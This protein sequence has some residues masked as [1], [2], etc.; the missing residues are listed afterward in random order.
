MFGLQ[1]MKR[2]YTMKLKDLLEIY[3]DNE[4]HR[5]SFALGTRNN[6]LSVIRMLNTMEIVEKKVKDVHTEELQK[7]FTS[8]VNGFT[9]EDGKYHKPYSKSRICAFSALLTNAFAYAVYPLG[10][11]KSNPMEHVDISVRRS[12][13]VLFENMNRQEEILTHEQFLKICDYLNEKDNPDVLP[14]EIAYYTG[15]RIGEVCGLLWDD[16]HLDEQYLVVQRAVVLNCE[17]KNRLEF[18]SPKRDKGRIVYFPNSLK[19]IL[20]QEKKK[21]KGKTVR[22]YYMQV[23]ENETVHY[24]LYFGYSNSK[25]EIPVDL[26]C[27]KKDGSYINRR[28]LSCMCTRLNNYIDGLQNFHFHMLR[29]TYATNLI[30][31]GMNME[32]IRQL[33]GHNDIRTTMNIYVHNRDETLLRKVRKLDKMVE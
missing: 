2:R 23:I 28:S 4:I 33:M 1:R 15:L 7:L 13:Q 11:I 31:L 24:P 10:V 6:Y 26:V 27:V 5:G 16:I 12:E 19:K 9:E 32:E 17:N 29:H 21:R 8:F 22:N 14:I 18:T 25:D 20:V 3:A 30:S